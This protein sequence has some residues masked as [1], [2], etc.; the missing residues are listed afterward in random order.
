MPIYFTHLKIS[1]FKSF[2]NTTSLDILPGLT[3]IVGPNGCGKSNIVEAIRWVMGESSA[4][5]LRGTGMDDV[6]FA[7]TARRAAFNIGEVAITLEN[8]KNQTENGF[9]EVIPNCFH[10]QNQIEISRQIEREGGSQYRLNG[11]IQ[12]ARDI[13][14][15]FADLGSG[16]RSTAIISQNRIAQLISASPEERRQVLEEAAGISGL[17]NRR[18][19]AELKLKATEENLDRLNDL[20]EQLTNQTQ[21]LKEQSVQATRYREISTAV[22]DKETNLQ[23]LYYQRAQ[24]QLL[25]LKTQISI[26]LNRIGEKENC[27]LDLHNNL[28]A[29]EKESA[30]LHQQEIQARVHCDHQRQQISR[31]ENE[32]NQKTQEIK[33]LNDRLRENK[34]QLI[35][36]QSHL[37]NNQSD[38]ENILIKINTI[39]EKLDHHPTKILQIEQEVKTLE[40]KS[41]ILLDLIH[42]DEKKLSAS[43]N[44]NHEITQYFNQVND[45][46]TKFQFEYEQLLSE[47]KSCLEKLPSAEKLQKKREQLD[48]LEKKLEEIEANRQILQKTI[49]S[50]E[51]EKE[52]QTYH[53]QQLEKNYNDLNQTIR[54]IKSQEKR[55]NDDYQNTINQITQ[56]Q[57]QSLATEEEQQFQEKL[58][59]TQITHEKSKKEI[60]LALE[61]HQ[62]AI[63]KRLEQENSY[64]QALQIHDQNKKNLDIIH[65]NLQQAQNSFETLT[66]QQEYLAKQLIAPKYLQEKQTQY[67]NINLQLKKQHQLIEQIEND[68]KK[69]TEALEKQSSIVQQHESEIRNLEARQQGLAQILK[70]TSEENINTELPAVLDPLSIPQKWI[71]TIA[72]I[73]DDTIDAPTGLDASRGWVTL[74]NIKTTLTGALPTLF[75]VISP[76]PPLQRAFQQIGIVNSVEEGNKLFPYLLPGQMLATQQGDIWR[77]DGY[78]QTHAIQNKSAQRLVQKHLL[79]NIEEDLKRHLQKSPQIEKLYEKLKNTQIQFKNKLLQIKSEYRDIEKRAQIITQDFYALQ[80]EARMAETQFNAIEPAVQQAQNEL[81][82]KKLYFEQAHKKTQIPLPDKEKIYQYLR[83]EQEKKRIVQQKKEDFNR[84]EHQYSL[85]KEQYQQRLNQNAQNKIQIESLQEKLAHLEIEIDR[86]RENLNNLERQLNQA[87]NPKEM[88]QS[89]HVIEDTI[90]TLSKKLDNENEF[91]LKTET[92]LNQ[93][94]LSYQSL[95]EITIQQQSRLD[96]L[97]PRCQKLENDLKEISVL[98]HQAEYNLN[99]RINCEEMEN[100]L[101]KLKEDYGI[102]ETEKEKKRLDYHL[103][104]QE[105]DNLDIQKKSLAQQLDKWQEHFRERQNEKEQILKK[106]LNLE[107]QLK[108]I[109]KLP[110]ILKS[111]LNEFKNAERQSTANYQELQKRNIE[112][113]QAKKNAEQN[114]QNIKLEKN[115]IQEQLIKAETKKE[116]AE[117]VFAQLDS[118]ITDEIKNLSNERNDHDLDDQAEKKLKN[119]IASLKAQR[120]ALGAVNLRAD[121]EYQEKLTELNHL[122]NEFNELT[123]AIQQ[124]RESICKLNK[125]GRSKLN[126]IFKEVDHH[127][128]ELFTRMFNGGQAYLKLLPHEDPLQSGLEIYAQ[129]PGKNLSTLSLLSG[130]EQAL[131]T[132][133]LVFAVSRCNPVPI[134]ILDE[135]DAPLDDP[136][137]ERFCKLLSDMSQAGTRFLV[138]T[139]HQLTMS[140]MQRLY[141]VTMQERGISQL[142]SIDLEDAVKIQQNKQHEQ[143]ELY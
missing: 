8:I 142:I 73:F 136:N 32:L 38:Q 19:E 43:I 31:L 46:K 106:I 108:D 68:L 50:K 65:T 83:I 40:E 1:G 123:T 52:K 61:H 79:Q 24:K 80:N 120:E 124:L 60:D 58:I 134:C 143:L 137:V 87:E 22:R 135:V 21:T 88:F 84:F 57:S 130:G 116:Q 77:W 131:T 111:K 89:V 140:H 93:A 2:A 129:P 66:K 74:S 18:R 112:Y 82:T 126:A 36:I 42:E 78:Y 101:K 133:S 81:K 121:L 102:N 103:I 30:T 34:T 107:N 39:N 44:K 96:A 113:D 41:A 45:E 17:Y 91:F 55:L 115:K 117:I 48:I 71:K 28:E 59:N 47:Q 27:I 75:D 139:H 49:Q 35:D 67:E 109:D 4:R 14:T 110:E 132:L 26:I 86:N 94:Q 104:L 119:S 10:N 54:Q 64:N 90:N 56:L 95:K 37:E 63:K 69:N 20:K 118:D 138:V 105:K 127:F 128:Q 97:T 29:M 51:F 98:F 15:L 100:K 70:Q 16:P 6:I 72:A 7:G 13:Q 76:P 114:L 125:Q 92:E 25:D 62:A 33:Q 3:G 5:S 23:I 122:E 12:R 99:H 53:A 85:V 141:G 11:K 9:D